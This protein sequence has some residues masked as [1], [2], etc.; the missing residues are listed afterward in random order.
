MGSTFQ[1]GR[2]IVPRLDKPANLFQNNHQPFVYFAG[3]DEGEPGRSHLAD[4]GL[5]R[6]DGL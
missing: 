1:S 4:E 3:Y 6:F 5:R 2:T